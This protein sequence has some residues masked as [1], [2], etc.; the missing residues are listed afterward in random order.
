MQKPA[1]TESF[2]RYDF[3]SEAEEKPPIAEATLCYRFTL[4]RYR[5]I[6]PFVSYAYSDKADNAILVFQSNTDLEFY[7]NDEKE[8]PDLS[9]EDTL[10][11]WSHHCLVFSHPVFRIYVNGQLGA[12]GLLSTPDPAIPLNGTLY[13]GQE[14]DRFDGGLDPSQSFSGFLAQIRM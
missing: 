14:Q 9:V 4:A 1:S 11:V 7:Y 6:V 12:Q 10:D 3:R 8:T 5:S 2:V 13:L